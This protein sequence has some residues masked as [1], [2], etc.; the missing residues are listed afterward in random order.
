MEGEGTTESDT[1]VVE[2]R[3]RGREGKRQREE[4]AWCAY[5]ACRGT[6]PASSRSYWLLSAVYFWVH[7]ATYVL[8]QACIFVSIAPSPSSL[9]ACLCIDEHLEVGSDSSGVV[10]SSLRCDIWPPHLLLVEKSLKLK[11][12]LAKNL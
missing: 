4:S 11:R 3:G 6:Q 5:A 7:I 9:S 12:V 1:G 8:Y 10:S 2:K